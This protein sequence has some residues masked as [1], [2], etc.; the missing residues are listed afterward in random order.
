MRRSGGRAVGRS[1]LRGTG[2]VS[3][4][5]VLLTAGPPGRLTAQTPDSLITPRIPPAVHYGKWAALRGSVVLGALA[6]AKNSDAEATYQQLRQRCFDQPFD[7]LV[8]PDGRYLDASSEALYD[9]TR[10]LDRQ[11]SRLLIG[12]EV[13]FVASAAGFVW[14]LMHRKD[15]T[16]TIPFEPRVEQTPTATRVSLTLRF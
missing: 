11:A 10:V 9:R 2:L 6:H 14:E 4:L 3:V 13:S 1:A 12:A 15:K 5:A 8:G 16:P 7:C